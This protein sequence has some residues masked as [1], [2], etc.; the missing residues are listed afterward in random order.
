M[1]RPK[2][3]QQNE[4]KNLI[5]ERVRQARQEHHPPLDQAD[6]AASL[7]DVLGY[8]IHRTTVTRLEMGRR[9]VTDIE[10]AALVGILNVDANWLLFGQ[11]AN[12]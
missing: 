3:Q 10:L 4:C 6:L 1:A 7:S 5:G 12:K 11:A 8:S 9:P 2:R